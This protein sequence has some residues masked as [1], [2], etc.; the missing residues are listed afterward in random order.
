M[1]RRTLI[2]VASVLLVACGGSSNDS[3]SSGS[4]SS[5]S[6]SEQESTLGGAESDG[7]EDSQSGGLLDDYYDFPP[8]SELVDG[9]P[10]P[11]AF[12]SDA[13]VSL[14]CTDGEEIVF[15]ESWECNVTFRQYVYNDFGWA[16]VDERIYYAGD[17]RNCV[18]DCTLLVVG[19][20]VPDEFN[21]D[22]PAGF[23]ISCD[24]AEFGE[25]YANELPCSNSARSFQ[26]NAIGHAFLDERVFYSGLPTC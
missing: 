9:Q 3:N 10:V 6:N 17:D 4:D 26:V 22:T 13:G 20:P 5:G 19:Q 16:F 2:V 11:E 14:S 21:L 23:D 7:D 25:V 1:I 8:C 18:P 24:S 15:G 12:T